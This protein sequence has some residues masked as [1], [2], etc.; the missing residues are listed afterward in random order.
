MALKITQAF[1][2]KVPFFTLVGEINEETNILEPL[3]VSGVPEI[4]INCKGVRRIN[5]IGVKT[6]V[7]L[8]SNLRNK[9]VELKF[10]ECSPALV[11]QA[12]LFP[13]FLMGRELV[14]FYGPF[15]CS[16]CDKESEYLFT[17][18]EISLKGYRVTDQ[19]CAFC[20]GKAEFDD[21]PEDYFHFLNRN[22]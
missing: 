18:S 21:V 13:N 10:V 17:P 19:K 8:F 22:A 4:R 6:W 9:G 3:V 1:D 5:S 14:S 12:N 11:Q 15:L 20:G 7:Q 16:D 2:G